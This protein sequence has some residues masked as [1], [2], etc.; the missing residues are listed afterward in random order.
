MKISGLQVVVASWVVRCFGRWAIVSREERALRLLE[1]S[2]EFCQAIDLDQAKAHALV[3]YVYARPKGDPSQELAGVGVTLAAAA[4]SVGCNLEKAIL[5]EVDRIHTPEVMAKC[6]AKQ[7][8]KTA[9]GVGNF[10]QRDDDSCPSCGG[11]LITMGVDF[12]AEA[13]GGSTTSRTCERCNYS[14]GSGPFSP[15]VEHQRP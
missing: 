6:L 4:T 13:G 9:A 15:P 12:S 11:A 8:A 3:D 10:G 7:R 14:E 2:L 5:A 1:E